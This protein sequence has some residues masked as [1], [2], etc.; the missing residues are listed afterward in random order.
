MA[1]RFLNERLLS[2]AG[3]CNDHRLRQVV[4]L[5]VVAYFLAGFIAVHDG[6]RAVHEYQSIV[7]LIVVE[8]MGTLY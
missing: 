4:S 1:P 2:V 3:A 6:H 7:E 5:H 8:E